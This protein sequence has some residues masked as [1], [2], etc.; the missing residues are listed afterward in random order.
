[1]KNIIG[2]RREDKNK[3]EVRV[4][5]IPEHIKHLKEHYAIQTF[6]QPFATRAFSDNEYVEA[7]ATLSEDLKE[8]SIIFAVKEVPIDLIQP[9]KAYVF[10]SHVI[11]GQSY[12]MPMLKKIIELKATIIDYELI[13][14]GK[15]RRLVFF[16]RYAG[17]AGMIDA[18]NVFGKKLKSL[19]H[20]SPFSGIKSSLEYKDL[21]DAKVHIAAIASEIK[22]FGL[23][24][25]IKP[26]VF[27]FAGYGHVSKGAQEILDLL[28]PKEITPEEL[29]NIKDGENE[30]YKVVFKEENIV[31][32][33]DEIAKFDLHEYYA[34][35]EKY[36]P[37]LEKYLKHLTVFV[38][39]VYW[40]ERYP[41][42]IIKKFLKENYPD[43]KLKLI[44]DIS[45]DID[46]GV[47][48]TYKATKPD[49]PAF[50]YN[51]SIDKYQDGFE[52]EG[53]INMTVDNLPCELPKDASV[54]FSTA[55]IPFV[56]R[57]AAADY[58]KSYENVE[59]PEEI[60]KAVIVYKGELT[61][62][63]EYLKKYL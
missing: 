50:T 17:L 9:N 11:K 33:K 8:P 10:F 1:M 20:N 49:N 60:K 43:L 15:N 26:C 35:P 47:E 32:P 29:V 52:G 6:V 31:E 12:N 3:W 4:P 28:N 41:K 58:S 56:P 63:Y 51:P 27:G 37:I 44:S 36:K 61:P 30:I 57:I 14:D 62:K 22:D 13:A 2:I 55:L 24:E 23:P 40:D 19:G 59:F 21:A 48:I 5:L 25:N 18:L 54:E 39:A 38:N 45:C 53:I 7:G 16:G 42:L 34:Q 46:G